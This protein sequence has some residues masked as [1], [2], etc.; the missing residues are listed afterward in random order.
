M[1]PY[2]R[3]FKRCSGSQNGET[4]SPVIIDG[5]THLGLESFIVDE[6]PEW[7]L[8][9][10]AFQVRMENTAEVLLASM[11][12]SNI[13]KSVVFPFPLE[14][15]DSIQANSYV[16]DNCRRYPGRFIPFSLLDDEPDRWIEQGTRGFKQHFLL[17][18]ERFNAI[19]VYRIIERSGLP[20]V[21]HFSTGRALEEARAILDIAPELTLIV[22]HMGRQV[23]NT[24]EGVLELAEALKNEP[25]VYLETSTVDDADTIGKAADIVGFDRIIF[26]SDFPFNS[27]TWEESTLHELDTIFRSFEDE[28]VREKILYGNIQSLIGGVV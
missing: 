28:K 9:K 14:E 18:P 3:Y 6:I 8:K 21:A 22:A 26:G 24:G 15:V 27:D 16:L 1:D 12:R 13:T 2:G 20:L 11:D 19:E 7:K 17:A 4:V 5:H 10:P 23:P 25:R